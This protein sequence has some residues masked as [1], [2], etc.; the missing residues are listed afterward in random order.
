MK[1]FS[2]IAIIVIVTGSSSVRYSAKDAYIRLENDTTE[3]IDSEEFG[4]IQY[5]IINNDGIP[6]L[7]IHGIVGGYDQGIQ[8]GISLLP[9][10]QKILSISRFG[11]LES[12]IPKNPTP[13]NQCKAIYRSI[14][15]I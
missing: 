11:Y 2:I 13:I 1:Y 3:I 9:N 7:I 5:K 8:T 12:N 4:S 15:S 10:N 6:V 14:R